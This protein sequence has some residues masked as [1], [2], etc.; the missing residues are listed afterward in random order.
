MRVPTNI[1]QPELLNPPRFNLE[2]KEWKSYLHTHGYVVIADVVNPEQITR[3]KDLFWN[4]IE[5]IRNGV[6]RKDLNTWNDWPERPRKGIFYTDG[7]GQSEFMWFLRSIP[8]VRAV[9]AEL[10]E[11]EDLI[12]SFD[13]ANAFRPWQFN[14]EWKTVGGW[15]HTDQNAMRSSGFQCAQGLVTLFDVTAETGGFVAVPQSHNHHTDVCLR[16]GATTRSHDFIQIKAKDPVFTACPA[17]SMICCKAGDIVLWDSR[18]IHCN[19][20]A[21]RR[22]AKTKS[23]LLRLVG[24]ICMCPRH[25]A[26]KKILDQRKEAFA[27]QI[28]T[29]HY[30]NLFRKSSTDQRTP[31]FQLTPEQK[32]LV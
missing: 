1:P 4:W 12:T 21:I 8:A 28:T 27:K 11:T 15:Y 32:S 22:P 24:Y 14:E 7:I 3:A 10:W 30:P 16:A 13:G 31:T 23:D 20:P 6:D 2:T 29:S 25:T 5:G 26:T 17:P 18:T 9:F 19:A